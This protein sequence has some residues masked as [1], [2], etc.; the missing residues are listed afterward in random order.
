MEVLPSNVSQMWPIPDTR[1]GALVYLLEALSGIMGYPN[2]RRTMS[3]MA[4]MFANLVVPH[5][6]VSTVLVILQPAVGHLCMF[7]LFG[8][9]RCGVSVPGSLVA[10]AAQ[11]PAMMA[12]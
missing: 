12:M 5:V 4:L 8:D 10:S 9:A 2:R 3:W 6:I 7:C 1:L 11:C